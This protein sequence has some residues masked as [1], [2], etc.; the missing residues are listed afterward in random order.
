MIL[1]ESDMDESVAYDGPL[2]VLISKGSASASEI[3]AGA[4][5]DWGR[6]PIVGD[7]S[8]FGKGTVQI[9]QNLKPFFDARKVPYAFDPGEFKMPVKKFYRAGGASTQINGVTSDIELPSVLSYYDIGERSMEYPLPWDEVPSANPQNLNRVAPYLADLREKS[10]RR[11]ASEKEFEYIRQD[12][13][14]YKKSQEDKSVSLNEPARIAEK[15]TADARQ[16]ARKKERL[17]RAKSG[18]ITLKNVDVA[19]LQPPVVKTNATAAASVE[20]D[21]FADP[22]DSIALDASAQDPALEEAKRILADYADALTAKP[23]Q[24]FSAQTAV[25]PVLK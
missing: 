21:P 3:V 12:I 1:T 6:A 22:D 2:I 11:I 7:R 4:L 10:A 13:E 8:T 20:I 23:P 19:G 17:A 16:E 18:E 24:V 15:K 14:E 5:Q 9:V 25:A